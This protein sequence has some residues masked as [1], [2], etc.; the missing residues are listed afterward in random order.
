MGIK[1]IIFPRSLSTRL[2]SLIELTFVFLVVLTLI[3]LRI[4]D[5]RTPLELNID[6]LSFDGNSLLDFT[7]YI[8]LLL[9]VCLVIIL[10]ITCLNI[11]YIVTIIGYCLHYSHCLVSLLLLF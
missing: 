7:L 9:V 10:T 4:E 8:M 3:I 2:V 11:D 6:Y 5:Y 1:V